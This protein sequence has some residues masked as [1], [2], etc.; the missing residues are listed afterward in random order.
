MSYSKTTTQTSSFKNTYLKL[1]K[2]GLKIVPFKKNTSK[3]YLS[4]TYLSDMNPKK[5]IYWNITHNCWFTS[6]DNTDY[7]LNNGSKWQSKSINST[8]SCNSSK[9]ECMDFTNTFLK[10]Y[11]EGLKI[12]PSDSYNFDPVSD[13]SR[14]KPV[15]WNATHNCWFTSKD[16]T[17][18]L[19]ENG[20]Q[21][22]S[23]S[24]TPKPNSLQV[25]SMDFTNTF[26]IV[27]KV[28]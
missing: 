3:K 7:L 15:Y 6:T 26:R 24:T 9:G 23:K 2:N 22:W 1:Y 21:W 5:P 18:Y 11:K 8:S 16:N 14:T 17:D 19:V 25:E 12:V 10:L 20:S 13:M 4:D 27:S 28:L